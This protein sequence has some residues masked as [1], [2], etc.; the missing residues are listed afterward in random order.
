MS[1]MR[2]RRAR[3]SRGWRSSAARTARQGRLARELG[4]PEPRLEL[5]VFVGPNG[6]PLDDIRTSAERAAFGKAAAELVRRLTM[7]PEVRLHASIAGGRKTMGF[8]RGQSMSLFARRADA[9]SHVLVPARYEQ[10][11][12]FWHPTARPLALVTRRGDTIDA[13]LAEVELCIVPFV[14]LRGRLSQRDLAESISDL[15][16]LVRRAQMAVDQTNVE[17]AASL[18]I[19]AVFVDRAGAFAPF[20]ERPLA[21]VLA[22]LREGCTITLRVSMAP[23]RRPALRL[24][25]LPRTRRNAR[26]GAFRPAFTG[27]GRDA[28]ARGRGRRSEGVAQRG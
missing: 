7:D 20:V 13:S 24:S 2:S 8:L 12:E 23:E 4:F 22:V 10:C 11:D 9:L 16:S 5:H 27:R 6:E 21:P 25:R 17:A 28:G 26:G 15:G 14:R 1:C 19:D 3:R 18:E